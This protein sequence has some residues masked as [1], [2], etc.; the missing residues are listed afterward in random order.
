MSYRKDKQR[1]EEEIAK[2]RDPDVRQRL[3]QL[4]KKREHEHEEWVQ[5][6]RSFFKSLGEPTQKE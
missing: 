6:I 2:E 1:L 3:Q 5:K 4:L